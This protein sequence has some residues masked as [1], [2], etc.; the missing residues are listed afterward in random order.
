MINNL[1]FSSATWTTYSLILVGTLIANI[2][3]LRGDNLFF[4]FGVYIDSTIPYLFLSRD[5]IP[6]LTITLSNSIPKLVVGRFQHNQL[7]APTP[8]SRALRHSSM[9]QTSKYLE[10]MSVLFFD[11][12]ISHASVSTSVLYSEIG[13]TTCFGFGGEVCLM[14]QVDDASY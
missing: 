2:D 6:F 13:R 5:L 14:S 7:S 1:H 9:T 4:I 11:D 10:A 8:L 12:A 3:F